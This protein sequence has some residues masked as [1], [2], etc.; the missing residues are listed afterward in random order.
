VANRGFSVSAQV[1]TTSPDGVIVAQGGRASGYALFLQAGKLAFAVRSGGELNTTV[2]D[3]PLPTGGHQVEARVDADGKAT[4]LIDGH[5][6]ATP[7]Q[8]G[9]L[10]R[11]PR[12]GLTIGNDGKGAVGDYT[13]PHPLAGKVEGVHVK[14]L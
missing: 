12:E 3:Q 10:K 6:A 13:A 2:S 11:Q 8:V 1:E 7:K 4:L 5:S 9:L 14:P